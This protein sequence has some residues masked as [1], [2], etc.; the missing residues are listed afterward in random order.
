M[1]MGER[2]SIAAQELPYLSVAECAAL[3]RVNHKTI[4]AEIAA[5]RIPVLRVGRLIR[6]P[7]R[8]LDSLETQARVATPEG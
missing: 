4:R 8:V 6:I 3:L 5:G 2:T 7:R 1:A